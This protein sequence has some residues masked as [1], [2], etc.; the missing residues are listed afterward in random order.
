MDTSAFTNKD[1]LFNVFVE[2]SHDAYFLINT[3]DWAIEWCNQKSVNLF[4]MDNKEEFIGLFG[5]DYHVDPY[6]EAD[7]QATQKELDEKGLFRAMYR[8]RTKKGNLFWGLL[9]TRRVKISNTRYQI[10][11]V[12]DITENPDL[13][14]KNLEKEL[15]DRSFSHLIKNNLLSILGMVHLQLSNSKLGEAGKSALQDVYRRINTIAVLHEQLCYIDTTKEVNI[16]EYLKKIIHCASEINEE[17]KIESSYEIG[18]HLFSAEDTLKLGMIVNELVSNSI[19]HAFRTDRVNEV[20]L[21]IGELELKKFKFDYSDNGD[22]VNKVIERTKG[23]GLGMKVI[24][25][26]SKSLGGEWKDELSPSGY[27]GWFVFS[28]N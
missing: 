15:V 6:T 13:W 27:K 9:D 2:S 10:V 5:H 26:L 18:Q 23:K 3:I 17:L 4:E 22:G 28:E 14:Q 20:A 21:A 11:K 8:Y 19:K 24:D 12:I 25:A 16:L 7:I 1:E